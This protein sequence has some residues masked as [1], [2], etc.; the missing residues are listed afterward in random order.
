M[1]HIQTSIFEQN[2]LSKTNTDLH[3]AKGRLES[4]PVETP[5]ASPMTSPIETPVGSQETN[6]A[7]HQILTEMK[8]PRFV[9]FNVTGL[10][11]D[12][13]RRFHGSLRRFTYSPQAKSYVLIFSLSQYL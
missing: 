3:V 5:V 12:V 2:K 11:N 8:S 7:V 4:T 9:Y 13:M 10:N 1:S 6:E